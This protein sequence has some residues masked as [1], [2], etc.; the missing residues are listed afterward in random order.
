MTRCYLER[1][2]QHPASRGARVDVHLHARALARGHVQV[3]GRV[4]H[5]RSQPVSSREFLPAH[6]LRTTPPT[7][8]ESVLGRGTCAFRVVQARHCMTLMQGG[9]RTREP[10]ITKCA[11]K[12]PVL[13]KNVRVC[14]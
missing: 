5:V 14:L 8:S 3:T 4:R 10:T 12:L 11:P 2:G 6:L 9:G 13:S 1:G 7:A